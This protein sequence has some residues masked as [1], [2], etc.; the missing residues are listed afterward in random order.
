[1]SRHLWRHVL[2]IFLMQITHMVRTLHVLWAFSLSEAI[3]LLRRPEGMLLY[4]AGVNHCVSV[5]ELRH[6]ID[7][8]IFTCAWLHESFFS[9]HLWLGS[10]SCCNDKESFNTTFLCFLNGNENKSFIFWL[11]W[12]TCF[13]IQWWANLRIVFIQLGKWFE[14]RHRNVCISW[15]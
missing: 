1:M 9:H 5:L 7:M 12:L 6:D 11:N 4:Y 8:I 10:Y 2:G 13:D 15:H 3:M 14:N